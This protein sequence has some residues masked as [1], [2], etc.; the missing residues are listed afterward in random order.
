MRHVAITN[1]I[2]MCLLIIHLI[3]LTV[4]KAQNLLYDNV[5]DD[6]FMNTGDLN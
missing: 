5:T 4:T 2:F 3:F 1:S 6:K